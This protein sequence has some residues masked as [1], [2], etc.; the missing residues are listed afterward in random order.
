VHYDLGDEERQGL[1]EFYRYA[2]YYGALED[3]S[4]IRFFDE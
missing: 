2:F 4:D 1:S 3:I